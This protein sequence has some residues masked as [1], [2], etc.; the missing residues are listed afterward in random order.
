MKKMSI[1]LILMF[2]FGPMTTFA[3]H[4]NLEIV[5]SLCMTLNTW[6]TEAKCF[7]KGISNILNGDSLEV[8]IKSACMIGSTWENE[9]KCF[10]KGVDYY[11]TY[12][13]QENTRECKNFNTWESE[14][15]CFRRNINR[16]GD[17]NFENLSKST[18]P[19]FK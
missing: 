13:M 19:E 8:I 17:H 18:G 5:K 4:A 11:G 15:K 6:E 16:Y 9:S 2:S 7:R 14:A 10:R 1:A 12:E 3:E